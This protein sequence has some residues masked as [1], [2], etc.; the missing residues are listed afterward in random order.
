MLSPR[1]LVAGWLIALVGAPGL[2]FAL[3]ALRRHVGLPSVLLLF[4]VLVVSTALVGGTW[5]ALAAAF[6]AS[7]LVNWYFTPPFYT[8]TIQH[9]Q[10]VLA[11]VVFVAVASTVSA[12]VSTAARRSNEAARARGEA[13]LLARVSGTLVGSDDPIPELLAHVR[14]AYGLEAVALMRP[15]SSG[16]R[17]EAHSGSPC[18]NDPNQA[19]EVL[20]LA[21]GS[22]LA[23]VGPAL[24]QAD[25]QLL[26]ALAAQLTAALESKRLRA[27]AAT[28]NELAAANELGTA[29]LAAVSHDLRTPLS[30]IKASVTSLLQKD[31]EWPD[32]TEAEFLETIN[33]E[34]DRLNK[35]VG[36]LLDMSRL[37]TGRLKLAMRTV[38]LEE[39]VA[40]A[41]ATIGPRAREIDIDVPETLPT[42][43]ADGPLL[44]RAV[45]NLVDNALAHGGDA[46]VSVDARDSDGY[47]TLRVVDHGPGIASTE[48]EAA[49]T[50]FRRLGRD[51][52]AR[53]VGLGLAVA[54]GFVEAVGGTLELGETAGGGLTVS[55]SL[56]ERK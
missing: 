46:P 42:V 50:P 54:R 23:L 15:S 5:P 29:L 43:W 22:C 37:Q 55:V 14:S 39:V 56:P 18:P 53:G 9:P 36:N 32:M 28:A 7:L 47:V 48:R 25:R 40:G 11:L 35:I 26:N 45:A 44:E 38:A 8:F 34:T 52:A 16:W 10:N 1:R 4:L 33:A 30:S 31:V 20:R 21:D 3:T 27:E 17:L 13:E 19:D 41:L 12:L 49:L 51:N 24:T 2:T 6:G